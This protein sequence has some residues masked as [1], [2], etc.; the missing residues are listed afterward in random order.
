M[1]NN[2][3]NVGLK[4]LLVLI[5]AVIGI[6]L[7]IWGSKCL[8]FI[9]RAKI[10][11]E[12][13]NDYFIPTFIFFSVITLLG[14]LAIYGAT[15]LSHRL[16]PNS[17]DLEKFAA[18]KEAKALRVEQKN[19]YY[20]KKA[21]LRREKIARK[22][23]KRAAKYQK[24]H[25]EVLEAEEEAFKVNVAAASASSINREVIPDYKAVT[26]VSSVLQNERSV[27]STESNNSQSSFVTSSENPMVDCQGS[28]YNEVTTEGLEMFYFKEP[29]VLLYVLTVVGAVMVAGFLLLALV[30]AKANLEPTASFYWQFAGIT[31]GFWIGL[32]V[33]FSG[34]SWTY[35]LETSCIAKKNDKLYLVSLKN[36]RIRENEIGVLRGNKA[37]KAVNS[38]IVMASKAEYK[39][40][41][42]NQFAREDFDRVV[43]GMIDRD[44]YNRL[45]ELIDLHGKA[46]KNEFL[47]KY[48]LYLYENRNQL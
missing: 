43:A 17:D 13:R 20:E 10:T 6:V 14:I 28:K 2:E 46:K 5:I 26:P 29:Y 47:I 48:I 31:V 19:D 21:A 32:L 35:V 42:K 39:L 44:D 38:T 30:L 22:A 37:V 8:F 12:W 25:Q 9:I 33:M 1:D 40:A 45:F 16:M 24:R 4:R 7:I 27:G 11:H 3:N 41:C 18:R 23:E 15:R 34:T 36:E